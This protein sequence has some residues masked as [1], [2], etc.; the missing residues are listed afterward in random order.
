[1]T[2]SIPISVIVPGVL[3]P[4]SHALINKSL[5][6]GHVVLLLGIENFPAD[7]VPN[8]RVI[9][10]PCTLSSEQ[11]VVQA[12]H[13]IP[14]RFGRMDVLIDLVAPLMPEH[15]GMHQPSLLHVSGHDLYSQ[16]GSSLAQRYTIWREVARHMVMQQHGR[17]LGVTI[18]PSQHAPVQ[19]LF[20]DLQRHQA[21]SMVTHLA[22]QLLIYGVTLNHLETAPADFERLHV[23]HHVDSWAYAPSHAGLTGQNVRFYSGI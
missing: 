7:Y 20:N 6:A 21:H 11:A 9:P 10:I 3:L 19:R 5:N 13:D 17:I 4:F 22:E 2:S 15:A 14:R 23:A 18:L 1:M 16:V 12:F 8:E